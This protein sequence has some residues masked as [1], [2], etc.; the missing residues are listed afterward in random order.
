MRP[1]YEILLLQMGLSASRYSQVW[2]AFTGCKEKRSAVDH[3]STGWCRAAS[4]TT[5]LITYIQA[6]LAAVNRDLLY[7]PDSTVLSLDDDHIR[8]VSRAVPSLSFLQK[9]NNPKKRI[10]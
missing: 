9:H 5:S 10:F 3:S 2:S 4:R 8:M 7:V 6:E 1:S